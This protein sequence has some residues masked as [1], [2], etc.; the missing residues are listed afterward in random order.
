MDITTERV[1]AI[2]RLLVTLAAM[3]AGGVGIA[4][5][6]DALYTVA[7]CALALVAS[8]YSWW[9]NNNLTEAAAQAQAYL[10]TIKQGGGAE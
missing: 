9:K 5:D 4:L 3:V 6:A 1:T 7:A 10:D 8:A 2:A